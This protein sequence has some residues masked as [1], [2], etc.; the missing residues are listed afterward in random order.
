M[1][2]DFDSNPLGFLFFGWLYLCAFLMIVQKLD[3][4]IRGDKESP[5]V[6]R[7]NKDNDAQ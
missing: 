7:R 1:M 3:Q 2:P 6:P 4:W 5:F